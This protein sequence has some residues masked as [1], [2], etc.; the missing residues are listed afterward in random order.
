MARTDHRT[1]TR[2]IRE[3]GTLGTLRK[4]KPSGVILQRMPG[5][6]DDEIRGDGGK[7][8]LHRKAR[9]AEARA[10]LAGAL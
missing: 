10:E 4:R 5:Y 9:R 7:A 3:Q 1:T 8:R 2:A 6:W